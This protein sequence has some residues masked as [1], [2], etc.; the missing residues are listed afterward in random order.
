MLQ[1]A[2]LTLSLRK[3]VQAL[4]FTRAA[5]PEFRSWPDDSALPSE[6]P[7]YQRGKEGETTAVVKPSAGC[8]DRVGQ[9]RPDNPLQNPPEV[10]P[11]PRG[12]AVF[13]KRGAA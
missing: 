13:I 2:W 7:P 8:R 12:D 5:I 3:D 11:C 4:E 9:G 6:N 1:L 10:P